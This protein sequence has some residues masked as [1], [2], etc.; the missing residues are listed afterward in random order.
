[1]TAALIE[2]PRFRLMQWVRFVGGEGIVQSYEPH[3]GTWAYLVK[4]PL[5]LE[6]VFGRVGAE[7]MVLLNEADL[8]A[9]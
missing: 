8:R 5:G 2:R 9:A 4:M 3:A 7:T 6:P 1:M